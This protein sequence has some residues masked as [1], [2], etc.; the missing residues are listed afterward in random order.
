MKIG[1]H[2][3]IQMDHDTGDI[4]QLYHDVV[5]QIVLAEEMGFDYAWCVEHHFTTGF[6]YSSAPEVLFGALSQRTSRIRLG[7]GVVLALGPMNHPIRV[8]ERVAML[9]HLTNGRV[10]LGT[11]RSSAFEQLGFQ[12]DP[13]DTR[14]MWDECVR[15]IPK[16]WTRER[17]SWEGKF[18]N[19]P[20]RTILPKPYQNPH[21]PMWLAGAQPSSFQ[22]AAERGLG[23]MSMATGVPQRLTKHINAYRETIAS[24]EPVGE[25]V[26]NQWAN[27][28]ICYCDEDDRK[29]RELG[30]N[31]MKHFFGGNSPY[32]R[33]AAGIYEQLVEDWGGQVPDHLK[34]TLGKKARQPGSAGLP[35]LQE[36]GRQGPIDAL[37]SIPTDQMCDTGVVIAGD[38]ETCIKGIKQHQEVGIDQMM[39]LV[40][41]P[42]IPHEKIVKSLHLL[43]KYV[44]PKFREEQQAASAATASGGGLDSHAA[45][46]GGR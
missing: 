2:Y 40:Q 30:A 18:L 20:E 41:T 8:A 7:H 24:A 37:Q 25:F 32:T 27:F 5:E 43:G 11:G 9:D 39:L 3:E 44:L 13:R 17:F 29:G 4:H 26:N 46:M 28:T 22:V 12:I 14:D 36:G 6:S 10:D 23:V 42:L 1:I 35:G 31:A 38:P 33:D 21:P 45:R 15:M 19:I 16:M 34:Y